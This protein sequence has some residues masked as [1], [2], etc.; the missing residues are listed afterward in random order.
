MLTIVDAVRAAEAF[1]GSWIAWRRTG[2]NVTVTRYD[3]AAMQSGLGVGGAGT[4]VYRPKVCVETGACGLEKQAGRAGRLSHTHLR[5]RAP[6]LFETGK[7]V[8]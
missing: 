6:R 5:D 1:I 4:I 3:G 2:R 7:Q 8:N